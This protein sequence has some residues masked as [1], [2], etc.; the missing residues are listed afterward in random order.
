MFSGL[1]EK[2]KLKKQNFSNRCYHCYEFK[3]SI[4]LQMKVGGIIGMIGAFMLLISYFPMPNLS[5]A[6]A[7]RGKEEPEPTESPT[8]TPTPIKWPPPAP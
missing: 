7:Q 4:C 3:A 8:P 2:K 6:S 1:A 5:G